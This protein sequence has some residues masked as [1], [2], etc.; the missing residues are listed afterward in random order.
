MVR[1]EKG[2]RGP[3]E[4]LA[5]QDKSLTLP[6]RFTDFMVNEIRKDGQVLHLEDYNLGERPSDAVR[7]VWL[8]IPGRLSDPL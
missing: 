4:T 8:L 5:H 7:N 2:T 1:S 3:Y 6:S